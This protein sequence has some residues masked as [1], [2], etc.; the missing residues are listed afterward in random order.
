MTIP[1]S[2]LTEYEQHKVAAIAG[3]DYS[4]ERGAALSGVVYAPFLA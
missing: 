1:Q 4:V 2:I 3:R